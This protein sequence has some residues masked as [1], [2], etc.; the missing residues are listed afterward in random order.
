MSIRQDMVEAASRGVLA[1]GEARAIEVMVLSR[2][3]EDGGFRGRTFDPG[4]GTCSDLY[5]TAFAL[6]TLAALGRPFPTGARTF[7]EHRLADL[8]RLDLVSVCCLV[9]GFGCAADGVSGAMA[10]PVRRHLRE[11]V[12][13]FRT[14]EGGFATHPDRS[15]AS[16]YACFL[17]MACWRI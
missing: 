12:A 10:E 13:K 2:Q 11:A 15:G 16:A 8:D 14:S 4:R 17:A 3:C 1:L 5:Y 7:L 6:Q 9:R